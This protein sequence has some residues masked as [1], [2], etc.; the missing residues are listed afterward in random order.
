MVVS[1][2][3]AERKQRKT[4]AFFLAA[5]AITWLLQLPAVLALRG[6]IAGPPERFMGLVGLG[7]FGPMLAAMLA[8]RLEGSGIR[9]LFRPMRTWRVGWQWYAVA[10]FLPG[11]IFTCGMVVYAL[12]G[13]A[14]GGPF[15]YV[16]TDAPHIL[17]M[18]VFPLGEEVGWRG[19]AL[20]RLQERF[21]P[22]AASVIIGV[23]W[24]LWHIPMFVLSGIPLSLFGILLPFFVAGSVV[25]TWVYN[26]TSQSLLLAVLVHVG[27]HLNNSHRALPGNVTPVVVHTVAY[28]IVA[29]AII[30]VDRSMR[31]S[32]RASTAPARE[33]E[34]SGVAPHD[35]S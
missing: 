30:L 13:G 21:G 5:Y 12:A 17:A 4:A 15:F 27:V 23:L 7:A 9:A 33:L 32:R 26:H 3:V 8:A 25:F 28:V 2:A 35:Q 11:A 6:V 20:P 10:L 22:L 29:A 16:P 1:N 14:H 18:I 24:G 31:A 34:G 19:F